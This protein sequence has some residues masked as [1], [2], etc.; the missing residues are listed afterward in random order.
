MVPSLPIGAEEHFVRIVDL[1]RMKS[2]VYI[3]D[4]GTRSDETEIPDE[5]MDLAIEYREK[6]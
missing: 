6:C 2:I 1:I 4:L 5:M 3:D